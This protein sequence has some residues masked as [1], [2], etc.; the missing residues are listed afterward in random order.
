MCGIILNLG[1][2]FMQRC[3]LKKTFLQDARTKTDHN[4]SPG[5]FGPGELKYK[6]E[7]LMVSKKNNPFYVRMG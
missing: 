5:A 6:S 2:W 7:N 3:R 4:S 1:P